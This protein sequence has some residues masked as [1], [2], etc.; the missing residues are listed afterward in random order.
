M[1][2]REI[3]NTILETLNIHAPTKKRYIRANNAPFLTTEL[4][5]AI[6]V[7]TRLRNKFLK[8]NNIESRQAYNKQ[9]NHCVSLL[10]KIKKN[11]LWKFECKINL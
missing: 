6:M 4:C 11:A 10:R 5:K 8:L 3:E 2:C 7:R 9:R 1:N